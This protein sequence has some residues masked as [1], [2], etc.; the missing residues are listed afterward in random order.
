MIVHYLGI[1]RLLQSHVNSSAPSMKILVTNWPHITTEVLTSWGMLGGSYILV[2]ISI[3]SPLPSCILQVKYLLSDPVY[4]CGF[5]ERRTF[6]KKVTFI[7]HNKIDVFNLNGNTSDIAD[8]KDGQNT[9]WVAYCDCPSQ[10]IVLIRTTP[11]NLTD[12]MVS[13]QPCSSAWN[14]SNESCNT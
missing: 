8:D 1:C 11:P 9:V 14:L 13:S 2:V 7:V 12:L 3:L 5:V 10:S 6:L 4:Y